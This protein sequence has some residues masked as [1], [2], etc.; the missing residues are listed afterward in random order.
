MRTSTKMRGNVLLPAHLPG[1]ERGCGGVFLRQFRAQFRHE[2][3]PIPPTREQVISGNCLPC[4]V[5]FR[6]TIFTPGSSNPGEVFEKE[7]ARLQSNAKCKNNRA[8]NCKKRSFPTE[9][10]RLD[11]VGAVLIDFLY[12]R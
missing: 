3:F 1:P 9:K 7:R 6:Y 2:Y 4:A 11:K 8:A 10:K 5:V 12:S